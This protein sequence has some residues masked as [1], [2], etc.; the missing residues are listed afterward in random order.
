[1]GQQGPH[2][3]GRG[4]FCA[5]PDPTDGHICSTRSFRQ[6]QEG[7]WTD[8]PEYTGM[9]SVSC[10]CH[11]RCT[12]CK[13]RHKRDR[14][15]VVAVVEQS[16]ST[17][18]LRRVQCDDTFTRVRTDGGTPQEGT[19]GSC[20]AERSMTWQS[21]RACSIHCMLP[22]HAGPVQAALPPSVRHQSVCA[23]L[24]EES[25]HQTVLWPSAARARAAPPSQ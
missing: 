14:W 18:A 9:F 12:T 7:D 5:R 15:A 13:L 25:M 23:V 6:R 17:R 8:P 10:R 16:E 3:R 11:G 4:G 20:M 2:P 21:A 22:T 19:R 24:A 1:M